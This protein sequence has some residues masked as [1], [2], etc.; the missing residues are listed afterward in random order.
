MTTTPPPVAERPAHPDAPPPAPLVRS[1]SRVVA[2]VA[3]CLGAV[4]VLG[5]FAGSVV[6]AV[7]SAAIRTET[8]T[9]DASGL[10]ALELEASASSLTVEFGDV[11]SATLRVTSV[12]GADDWTLSR[13]GGT[14]VVR[15]DRDGRGDWLPR[16]GD[17]FDGERGAVLT[18]PSA[19]EDAGLD[20]DLDL[21]AGELRVEDGAFGDL[22]LNVSAG[23]ATV[24]GSA[25]ALTVDVSAG[26]ADV[27]VADVRTAD[28]SVRAGRLD[29]RLTGSAPEAV[30]V[31]ASAGMADIVLPHGGYDVS[32]TV[33]AGGLD[34][35]LEVSSRS[36]HTVDVTVSG[37]LVRLTSR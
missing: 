19:L 26:T 33:S 14:L 11:P 34:D 17:W 1:S 5:A 13:E 30:T 18:L 3:I 27:D 10:E 15:S 2:V 24:G 23:T 22:R 29:A 7:L 36:A 16:I 8:V 20:A 12:H 9:A 37:G 4:V 6:P 25:D 35:R 32:S 31:S 21:S 28:V